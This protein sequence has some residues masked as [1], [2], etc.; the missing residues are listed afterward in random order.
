MQIQRLR[1]FPA[2]KLQRAINDPVHSLFRHVRIQF[3]RQPADFGVDP[4]GE[5]IDCLEQ[6]PVPDQAPGADEIRCHLHGYGHWDVLP[7]PNEVI[8]GAEDDNWLK[9]AI[10]IA[11]YAKVSGM[12]FFAALR[13]FA[14]VVEEGG[15]AKAAR[16]M[17]VATSS[18]TRHVN[19]LEGRLRAQLLN[20]STR[21]VTLTDAGESYYEQAARIL[22]D[23]EDANRSVREAEGSPYGLLR[24][25]LP[26]AFGRLHVAPAI[27]E[28]L[29]ACPDIELELM[30]TDSV[31][32]LVEERV[33]LAIR[34]GNLQSS[35]LIARKIAPHRRV[36]CA[37]PDYLSE[38][39]EP[40]TPADLSQ[41][42]CLILSYAKGD[43]VWRFAGPSRREEVRVTGHLRANN[44]EVLRNAAIGGSGLILMPTWL[45]GNDLDA[46]RLRRLLTDWEAGPGGAAIH[47]VYLPN[48]KGSKKVLAFIDFLKARFGSPPY[49][50]RAS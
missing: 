6:P 5:C 14:A 30:M 32:N 3:E 26:V 44:S 40:R 2:S 48:R 29:S 20:R 15:F 10:F 7:F 18:V 23:L 42:A 25:S 37:S 33:D 50:D 13:A 43:Q 41:H 21:S 17:G 45:V 28:F 1:L 39:G 22:G 46:G 19:G 24:V 9:C 8:H 27:S 4:V 49:W 47:A 38:H 34:I 11:L 35:S 12:D 31:V 16:R 36:V